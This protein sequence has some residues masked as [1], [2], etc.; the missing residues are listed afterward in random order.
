MDFT[1][2]G[3][4]LISSWGGGGGGGGGADGWQ[5]ARV[6]RRPS[7]APGCPKEP[8]AAYGKRAVCRSRAD[9]FILFLQVKMKVWRV[10][11]YRPQQMGP[12]IRPPLSGAREIRR[13]EE[14]ERRFGGPDQTY[15]APP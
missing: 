4:A 8:P 15:A 7:E 1:L 9:E 10:A 12:L 5:T 11:K 3:T 6:C 2:P 14:K 13:K